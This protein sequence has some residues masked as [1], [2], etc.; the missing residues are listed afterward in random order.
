MNILITGGAGFI[1]SEFA[2]F[3]LLK[4][5]EV[6][7]LDTLEYGYRDNFEDNEYLVKN[8]I[9]DD[10]R[11]KDFNKY[12]KNIDI[13]VH[14]AGISALPEC[15]AN[16]TKAIDINITGLTNVLNACRSSNVKKIIFSSTSAVYEN[17]NPNDIYTEDMIVYPNLIYST[18]KYMAEQICKSYSQ[19][20]DMNIIICRFFNIY[21]PHQDFKRKYP[22]FTSYLIREIV[23]GIKPTIFNTSNVKRDYIYVDDLM[24]YMY[25]MIN[26]EKQYNSEIFNLCSGEGYSALEIADIIFK[27][28]NKNIEYNSGNPNSFW[29]KYEELFDK[30]YNL[31]RKRIEKE[32]FKNAIGS[33]VKANNEFN[34]IPKTKIIDGIK[35]IIDFQLSS[36]N[37]YSGGVNSAYNYI[38]ILKI[39]SYVYILIIIFLYLNSSKKIKV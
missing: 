29:D 10:I 23:N 3:L 20:Y 21:G 27:T 19:N 12:L 13:V 33:N 38:E 34:Y 5:N 16:P 22:P 31:S 32:V 8:F 15:E 18:T 7:I 28:L 4:G 26:S 24:E 30:N 37:K 35:H 36:V 39:I 17:N 25:R 1:G 11:S 9:L 2:K 14:L 6:K